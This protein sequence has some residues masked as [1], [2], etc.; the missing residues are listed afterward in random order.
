MSTAEFRLLK[1]PCLVLTNSVSASDLR[2]LQELFPATASLL[3]SQGEQAEGVQARAVPLEEKSAA[4]LNLLNEGRVVLT[5]R[6]SPD[7]RWWEGIPEGLPDGGMPPGT[8]ICCLWV[9]NLW[10]GICTTYRERENH[11]V[12]P[13]YFSFI[14]AGENWKAE[15]IQQMLRL[16]NDALS[17][18][19]E[20]EKNLAWLMVHTLKARQAQTL[21]ID[22]YAGDRPLTAGMLLAL[23]LTLSQWVKTTTTRDR[24]GLVLPPGLGA[25][26]ANL[27]C[28]LAG[29][30]PVNLNF[31]AGRL[32]NKSSIQQS[33]LDVIITAEAIVKRIPDFPWTSR[34][35]D[36]PSLLKSFSRI[37]ILLWR[38]AVFTLPGGLIAR[39]MG[40]PEKGGEKEAGLLFT[41]GSSGAPKGVVL[42][43]RNILSNILQ[44]E[45]LFRGEK[46]ETLLGCLPIF[47]SFG[48]TVTLWWPLISGPKWSPTS[49]PS[50]RRSWARLFTATTF[51]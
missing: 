10:D 48:F 20:L 16:G 33:N 2:R 15:A 47:H 12:P 3:L 13:L 18:R 22:A 14:E 9:D 19:S 28:L 38:A 44:V 8:R 51:T 23:A 7:S 11:A 39:L 34:R 30:T 26:I 24:V 27:A 21:V 37:K 41:S 49:R 1:G 46:V 32:A 29:K 17:K 50:R 42:T 40:I 43:H 35:H 5:S 25:F 4:V 36:L 45:T 31:T 6:L